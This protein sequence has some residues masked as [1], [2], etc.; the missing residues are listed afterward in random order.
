M[1]REISARL[2]EKFTRGEKNSQ[3]AVS[4]TTELT[5]LCFGA[6]AGNWTGGSAGLWNIPSQSLECSEAPGKGETDSWF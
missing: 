3:T 6:S 4:M 2:V 1:V 5:C